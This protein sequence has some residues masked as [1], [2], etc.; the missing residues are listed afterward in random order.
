[1]SRTQL[2]IK[3]GGAIGQITL[4]NS[5][6]HKEGDFGGLHS[7]RRLARKLF[8]ALGGVNPP[9]S[10]LVVEGAPI[11]L[12]ILP[13]QLIQV[14]DF[15]PYFRS[16]VEAVSRFIGGIKNNTSSFISMMLS[17]CSIKTAT[18]TSANP[19]CGMQFNA[20]ILSVKR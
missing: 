10:H 17:I 19:K 11:T 16:T 8:S 2:E 7:A 18:E 12:Y 4:K 14:A 15:Y 9:R 3:V 1:M 5:K 6:F 20:Y 13:M